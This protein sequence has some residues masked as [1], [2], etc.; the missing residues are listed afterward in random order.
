[1]KTPWHLWVIGL[2]MLLWNGMGAMDYVMTVSRNPDYLAQF[3]PERLAFLDAFPTWAKA[4]W[5][6]AVWLS[7]LGSVVLLLRSRHAVWMLGGGLLFMVITT[8][9]NLFLAD[10]PALD[11][12]SGFEMG[13]SL[14]I[15]V[16]A[17]AQV[18]YARA[19]AR[20]GVLA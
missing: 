19:M 14:V 12:M 11:T 13:F 5:A 16:L 9:H 1:M 7:V 20:R 15:F 4:S 18:V 8:I 6:L 3:T 10:V 2:L 17:I